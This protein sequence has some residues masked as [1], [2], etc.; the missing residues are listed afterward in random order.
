MTTRR[1]LFEMSVY[2]AALLSI[3]TLASVMIICAI[4]SL[5]PLS[6]FDLQLSGAHHWLRRD[7]LYLIGQRGHAGLV[8]R[9][10]LRALRSADER[11]QRH[12]LEM[13]RQAAAI[14]PYL[15][16]SRR[17]FFAEEKVLAHQYPRARGHALKPGRLHRFE[18]P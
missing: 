12:R 4:H 10:S 15:E 8:F 2:V 9:P 6:E 7:F 13:L 11:Q 3:R 14:R 1:T 16:A 18:H 17:R 5:A